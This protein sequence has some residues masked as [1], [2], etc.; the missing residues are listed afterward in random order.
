[1]KLVKL[2]RLEELKEIF[3]E[4]LLD[5]TSQVS[6]VSD[7]S[8]VN[9]IAYANADI[10]QRVIKDIALIE[11]QIFP[12]EAFGPYLDNAGLM[13]NAS[14][15]FGATG[16]STYV[17]I[18][19]LPNTTYPA[20]TTQFIST[21]GTVFVIDGPDF[22]MP[23]SV[24]TLTQGYAYVKV[25]STTVGKNTNTPALQI[26]SCN[27]AP[28]GHKYVINEY[29]SYGGAD[30]ES[31]TDYR[32]RIVNGVNILAR[33]TLSYLEQVFMRFNENVLKCFHYGFND[34]SQTQIGVLTRDGS[35][36]TAGQISDLLFRSDEYLNLTEFKPQGSNS[37]GIVILPVQWYRID[38]SFR[39][40]MFA[41]YDV[42]LVRAEIQAAFSKYLD[43][44]YWN[45]KRKVEWDDLLDIIKQTV[46]VRYVYDNFIFLTIYQ[47]VTPIVT[48]HRDLSI[49]RN[50]L[51]RMQ[52]FSMLD[53]SGNLISGATSNLNPY[54]FPNKPDAAYVANV[55]S[56]I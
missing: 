24:G 37:T 42:E 4:Q 5:R 44:R 3:I 28:A 21:T 52:G 30:V 10:A 40:E 49:P 12:T 29:A 50:S 56:T 38:I 53:E 46:G 26:N 45:S 17:K 8:V 19:A 13:W 2:T 16:S 54:Y 7:G 32:D 27:P 25:I 36:L 23:A 43:P 34:R 47:G 18:F 9:G 48:H 6:K 31:D 15:R 1:M 51:P 39:V 55:I 41:G 11:S 33:G 22:T 35:D 14:T 20:A